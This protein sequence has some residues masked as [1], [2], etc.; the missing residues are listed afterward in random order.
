M[1][2]ESPHYPPPTDESIRVGFWLVEAT[3]FSGV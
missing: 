3:I 2:F 1:R